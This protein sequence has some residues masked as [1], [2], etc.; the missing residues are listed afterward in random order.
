M[1]VPRKEVLLLGPSSF[2]EKLKDMRKEIQEQETVFAEA[3]IKIQS[4]S[5][6]CERLAGEYDIQRNAVLSLKEL[7][8]TIESDW[9][10]GENR[11]IDR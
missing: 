10:K 5:S 6:D 3:Y 4:G 9:S 2:E 1:S 11:V 8:R 7:Y